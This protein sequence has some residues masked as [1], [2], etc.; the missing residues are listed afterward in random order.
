MKTEELRLD[1]GSSRQVNC[2]LGL[3]KPL[4]IKKDGGD[5]VRG[6]RTS[7]GEELLIVLEECGELSILDLA[8]LMQLPYSTVRDWMQMFLEKG[9]V[10]R[11]RRRTGHTGPPAWYYT[12]VVRVCDVCEGAGCTKCKGSGRC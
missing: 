3:N 11:R 12:W 1:S 5:T 4:G 10:R 7:T 2:V 8:G 6:K 9:A